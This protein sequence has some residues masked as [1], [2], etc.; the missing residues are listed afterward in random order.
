MI[1]AQ[2]LLHIANS[3]NEISST[4][5]TRLKAAALMEYLTRNP[6]ILEEAIS[7]GPLGL[8]LC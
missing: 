1:A 4:S 5:I 3:I 2:D 8:L 6:T 7:G